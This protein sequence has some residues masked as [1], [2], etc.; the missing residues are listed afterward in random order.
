VTKRT[1]QNI[2]TLPNL[3]AKR[4]SPGPRGCA[5]FD[6]NVMVATNLTSAEAAERALGS[7]QPARQPARQPL[8]RL[9]KSHTS[10]IAPTLTPEEIEYNRK[11]E[12]LEREYFA[13]RWGREI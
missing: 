12:K 8:P 1:K 7:G 13:T 3:V 2:G 6:N 5:L 4:I 11:Q 10:L 9:P